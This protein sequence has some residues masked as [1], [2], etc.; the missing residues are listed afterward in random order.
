MSVNEKYPHL[1]HY[2]K[3]VIVPTELEEMEDVITVYVKL[4]IEGINDMTEEDTLDSMI[5]GISPYAGYVDP[6]ASGLWDAMY[7]QIHQGGIIEE[8][9]EALEADGIK[10]Q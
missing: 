6:G 3:E 1:R 10:Y 9:K 4:I 8:L 2:V 7:S 5:Q